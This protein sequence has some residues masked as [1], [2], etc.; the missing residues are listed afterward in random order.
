LL[1]GSIRRHVG[2]LDGGER[3]LQSLQDARKDRFF[4]HDLSLCL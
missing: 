2:L 4:G 1:I 3:D